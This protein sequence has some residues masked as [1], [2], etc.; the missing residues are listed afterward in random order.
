M[1]ANVILSRHDIQALL[2]PYFMLCSCD[3]TDFKLDFKLDFKAPESTDFVGELS[4]T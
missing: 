1:S 4:K 2:D 3:F